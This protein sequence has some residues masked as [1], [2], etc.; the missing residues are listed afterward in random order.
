MSNT[1]ITYLVAAVAGVACVVL[2]VWH[3]AAP[4][5]S[6]MSRWWERAVALVLSVYVLVA[7]VAAGGGA[8]AVLLYYYDEL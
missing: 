8:A 4:A 3:I 1:A 2:W 5:W 7:M 6:A